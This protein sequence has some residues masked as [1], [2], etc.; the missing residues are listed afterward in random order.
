MKQWYRHVGLETVLVMRGHRFDRLGDKIELTEKEY[1][2][3]V[4]GGGMFVTEPEFAG[5]KFTQQELARFSLAGPRSKATADFL[6]RFG[7]VQQIA[8]DRCNDLREKKKLFEEAEHLANI[9]PVEP[10][11]VPLS[12]VAGGQ[13]A[14][15]IQSTYAD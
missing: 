13:P 8:A 1:L 2:E 6:Q 7:A 12:A 9:A 15:E 5:G 3:I 11:E 4:E 14:E 10:E